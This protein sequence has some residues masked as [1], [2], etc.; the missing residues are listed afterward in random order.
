MFAAWVDVGFAFNSSRTAA[1]ASAVLPARIACDACWRFADWFAASALRCEQHGHQ[2]QRRD[3]RHGRPSIGVVQGRHGA[4]CRTARRLVAAYQSVPTSPIPPPMRNVESGPIFCHRYAATSG[5]GKN[6]ND[7]RPQYSPTA[8]ARTS[9]GNPVE[10]SALRAG[11]P[12]SRRPLTTNVDHE[13]DHDGQR[14]APPTPSAAITRQDRKQREQQE[15]RADERPRRR[16]S[17]DPLRDRHVGRERRDVHDR[18]QPASGSAAAP[19]SSPSCCVSMRHDVEHGEVAREPVAPA[20]EDLRAQQQSQVARHVPQNRAERH[21][22]RIRLRRASAS[23]A[24]AA[25]RPPAR[26]ARTPA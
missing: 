20:D 4:D 5:A 14:P 12:S 15:R 6:A 19:P 21:A 25:E 11:S 13:P 10:I 26:P 1:R 7:R 18:Q 17:I 8:R 24:P 9:G 2:T 3:E 16:R 22:R 23:S